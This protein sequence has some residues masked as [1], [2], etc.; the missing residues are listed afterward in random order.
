MPAESKMLSDEFCKLIDWLT[1]PFFY[2]PAFWL[3]VGILKTFFQFICT[4]R[5]L[6]FKMLQ[7]RQENRAVNWPILGSKSSLKGSNQTEKRDWDQGHTASFGRVA[8]MCSPLFCGPA[9]SHVTPP[10]VMSGWKRLK[11][12]FRYWR[13]KRVDVSSLYNFKLSLCIYFLDAAFYENRVDWVWHIR[14]KTNE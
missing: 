8:L 2:K 1:A 3:V 10:A 6:K 14:L 7:T 11:I 4:F 5:A 13:K 12:P 9:W